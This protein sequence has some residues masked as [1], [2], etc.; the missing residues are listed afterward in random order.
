MYMIYQVEYGDSI[1][2]IAD[3]V[4]TTADTIKKIQRVII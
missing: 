2:V 3:K 1:N 4:G